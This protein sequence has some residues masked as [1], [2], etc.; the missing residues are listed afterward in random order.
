MRVSF[1]PLEEGG[2]G[3]VSGLFKNV[4]EG[5]F[6]HFTLLGECCSR[7][8]RGM[9]SRLLITACRIHHSGRPEIVQ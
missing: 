8:V 7:R 2:G 6:P 5:L 1:T 9:T 3:G 4:F